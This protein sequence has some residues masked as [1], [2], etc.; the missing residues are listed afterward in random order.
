MSKDFEKLYEDWRKIGEQKPYWGVLTNDPFLPEN[1]DDNIENFYAMG[2]KD[3]EHLRKVSGKLDFSF[4]GKRVLD[5]GC[6]VGRLSFAMVPYAA[7]IVGV[8]IS[9][10]MLEKA[11]RA[12]EYDNVEFVQSSED[13]TKL[14]LGHFDGIISLL[15]LQ[16]NRPPLIRKFVE[17]LL[18]LLNPGGHAFLHIHTDAP[19]RD[20]GGA[21]ESIE[22]M[23]PMEM[24][25]LPRAEVE[26]IGSENDC[27]LKA[28]LPKGKKE[29]ITSFIFV[30]CR[31]GENSVLL[32]KR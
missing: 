25:Y 27:F 5:F 29:S 16:H 20:F 7:S 28:A 15:T 19:K 18:Q 10:G 2:R 8:D 23:E 6:G 9:E 22:S 11:R 12:S 14:N 17:Q 31:N 4:E 1:I 32:S 26:K 3:I 24:H 13:L 21:L 30:F